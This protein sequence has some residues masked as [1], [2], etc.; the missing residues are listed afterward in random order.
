[1]PSRPIRLTASVPSTCSAMLR[2]T[3]LNTL[4]LRQP[5]LELGY[6]RLFSGG[7]RQRFELRAHGLV[8]RLALQNVL[9]DLRLVLDQSLA[10]VESSHGGGLWDVVSRGRGLRLRERRL[11]VHGR[12]LLRRERREID[13]DP[14]R[15]LDRQ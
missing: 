11:V 13:V 3:S 1:M 6:L 2:R 4:H 5:A 8:L 14:R 12:L 15:R 9:V 10:G 7:R